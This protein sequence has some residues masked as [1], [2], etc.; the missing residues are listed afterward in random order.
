MVMKKIILAV[1]LS[2][3]FFSSANSQT[4]YTCFVC[5]VDKVSLQII[6]GSKRT[7]SG[8]EC[9]KPPDENLLSNEDYILLNGPIEVDKAIKATKITV[10][11]DINKNYVLVYDF[12]PLPLTEAQQAVQEAKQLLLSKFPGVNGE[13]K[14]ITSQ[15]IEDYIV[16]NAVPPPLADMMRFLFYYFKAGGGVR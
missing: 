16:A 3:F 5:K 6:E 13:I 7:W 9:I 14:N 15:R 2:T 4:I 1:L 8:G 11:K 10:T 12:T